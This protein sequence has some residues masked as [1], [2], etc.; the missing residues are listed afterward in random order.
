MTPYDKSN[1]DKR[2]LGFF[3]HFRDRPMTLRSLLWLNRIH[4]ISLAVLFYLGIRL[5]QRSIGDTG[6][7]FWAVSFLFMLARDL[8]RMRDTS[9]F[10]PTMRQFIDWEKLEQ[11]A[12]ANQGELPVS[13]TCTTAPPEA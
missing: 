11:L 4:Y 5:A 10:W 12:K 1:V 9:D 7:L 13:T 2:F 3:L 8:G 6:A